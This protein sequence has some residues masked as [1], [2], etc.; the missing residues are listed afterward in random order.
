MDAGDSIKDRL[1][2]VFDEIRRAT[3]ESGR[4]EHSVRLVAATKA[5]P[6]DRIR[7]AI[8]AGV[9]IVGE[10][11]LQEALAKI[12]ALRQERIAW[13]F[14]GQLQRRK[15]RSVIPAFELIH[16]VGSLELAMEIN[17]RAAAAGLRQ[18]I[19]LEVNLG[20]E[21]SKAGF[22]SDEVEEALPRL[23]ALD[24]VAIRGLMAIPPPSRDAEQSRPHFRRL[25]KLAERMAQEA[26]PGVSL[27][28]LSMG[29]SND[30]VVAIQ[31]GATLIRLGTAIFGGRRG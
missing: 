5:V 11:R 10:N 25:R 1:A 26:I 28:E 20:A 27:T 23:A 4:E 7:E 22:L 13:H 31:E 3:H 8:A 30:Y 12:E 18:K 24:H 14:I 9:Q 17:Q 6:V 19:L 16:S 21:Q 15:V 29:M 2:F